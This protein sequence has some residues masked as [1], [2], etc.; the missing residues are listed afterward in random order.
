M[1]FVINKKCETCLADWEYLP[2]D[3]KIRR[4]KDFKNQDTTHY[5]FECTCGNTLYVKLE[6]VI[7]QKE[8]A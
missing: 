1:K 2:M 4:Q 5:V 6:N 3:K 7:Y 8:V